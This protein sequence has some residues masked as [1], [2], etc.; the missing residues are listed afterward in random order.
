M[1][2]FLLFTHDYSNREFTNFFEWH[3]SL[4]FSNASTQLRLISSNTRARS[5]NWPKLAENY[6]YSTVD[7]IDTHE[8]CTQNKPK[9]A[10]P[11]NTDENTESAQKN[12]K[13]Q[14]P[15]EVSWI[16]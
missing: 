14:T 10:T 7:K 1:I 9:M 8:K 13:S 16:G 6:T 11:L 4:T 5:E 2:Y 15:V 3:A 12:F